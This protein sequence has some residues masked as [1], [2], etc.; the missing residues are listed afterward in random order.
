MKHEE[1]LERQRRNPEYVAV[2]KE[3]R[4]ILDI[5][6]D[7]LRLRLEKGWSQAEL[8]E[9]V[10]TKQ[11]NISRLEN[12]LANPSVELLQRLAKAFGTE[13]VV[14]LRKEA[15]KVIYVWEVKQEAYPMAEPKF[16]SAEWAKLFQECAS[17]DPSLI[18]QVSDTEMHPE[19]VVL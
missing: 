14:R 19:R 16:V 13:L 11:A 15:P 8:A 9:R 4:P 10:G 17:Y 3:L 1:Y 5:A 6:N 12:G 7:V 2:E 18:R